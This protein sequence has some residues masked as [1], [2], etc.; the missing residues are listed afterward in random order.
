MN[1]SGLTRRKVGLGVDI[2]ALWGRVSRLMARGHN[3][4]IVQVTGPDMG[5]WN[6][7]V[8]SLAFAPVFGMELFAHG[9]SLV[10]SSVP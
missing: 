2:A 6:P 4:L 10:D 8:Y 9:N 3:Q 5:E 1:C 7:R